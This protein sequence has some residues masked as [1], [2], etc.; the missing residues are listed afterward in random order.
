MKKGGGSTPEGTATEAY[1]EE[2]KYDQ[3]KGR[4]KAEGTIPDRL[5][6][7]FLIGPCHFPCYF[8]SKCLPRSATI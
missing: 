4:R 2:T 3:K 1:H 5:T 7:R 8:T 6:C